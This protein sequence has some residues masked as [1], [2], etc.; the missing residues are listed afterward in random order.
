MKQLEG[1][2]YHLYFD[3]FFSSVS[4]LTTLLHKG[5]YACGTARQTS[6][7]FPAALKMRGKG[8]CEMEMHGLAD[9]GDSQLVQQG[10]VVALLWRD[11]R[12]VTL[13]STNAQPQQ[14]AVVQRREH[15][16]S[17]IDVRCPAA[18]ELYNR[19]MGGVDKNDQ[20]W[21]Y[22]HVR[23]K[24][25]KCYHYIFW[26]LFE[27]AFTNAYILHSNYSGAAKKP[28]KE[29]RLEVVRGMIGDYNSRKRALAAVQWLQ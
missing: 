14:Q 10:G 2:K 27:V 20:L 13:L 3:N 15:D 24:S 6:R 9:R 22:Y 23:T 11:N 4:L 18:M 17:R 16:G 21:Q 19:F 12:V 5:I 7:E 28:M 8:K 25:W 1:K 29:F 26:F